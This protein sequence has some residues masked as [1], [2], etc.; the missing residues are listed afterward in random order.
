MTDGII[1]ITK[2]NFKQE[3]LKSQLPVL[4]DF[5]GPR[6]IPCKRLMPIFEEL[7]EDYAGKVKF[8]KINTSENRSLTQQFNVMSIPTL[9]FYKDGDIRRTLR[10]VVSREEIE[11]QLTGILD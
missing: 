1:E 9:H 6:C 4:V 7:A 2:E 8:C 11:E 5:W 10:G 3:V